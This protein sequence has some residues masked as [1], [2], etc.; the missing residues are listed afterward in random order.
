MGLAEGIRKHGFR[1]WYERELMQ[2]HLH[3][4]LLLFCA[5]GLLG[6]FE[7][8]SRSATVADQLSVALS[9]LLC[10]GIGMWSMRRYLYLLLHAERVANQA[11]CAQCQTYGRLAVLHVDS[12]ANTVG[13]RCKHCGHEW[14]IDG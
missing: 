7:V 1:K 10:I 8:F 12:P 13:V 14:P 6:A 5:I 2:S 4:L 11:V 3:M 9:V